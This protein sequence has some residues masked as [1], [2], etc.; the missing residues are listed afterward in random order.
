MSL[1]CTS[2]ADAVK[3]P[4]Q[5]T[6]PYR[7]WRVDPNDDGWENY[8]FPA[9]RVWPARGKIIEESAKTLE[10]DGLESEDGFAVEFKQTDGWILDS[11]GIQPQLPTVSLPIFNSS[12]GFFNKMGDTASSSKSRNTNNSSSLTTPPKTLSPSSSLNNSRNFR[13][14][15]PGTLGLSNMGNTC[16]MNSALQCLV[17]TKE[18]SDYFLSGFDLCFSLQHVT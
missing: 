15:V 8:D 18:L 9:E 14:L 3:T 4:E 2:L 1:L 16:F 10:E 5:T 12:E 7:I 13:S 17:H 11:Q 6:T